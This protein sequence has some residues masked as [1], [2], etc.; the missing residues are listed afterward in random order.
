MTND[1]EDI[2]LNVSNSHHTINNTEYS[3]SQSS[4]VS[5]ILYVF[6]SMLYI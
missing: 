4:S 1:F 2:R 5:N 3:T 6:Q